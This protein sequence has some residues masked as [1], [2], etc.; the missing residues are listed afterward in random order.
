MN[1]PMDVENVPSQSQAQVQAPTPAPAFTPPA[2][3]AVPQVPAI[4]PDVQHAVNMAIAQLVA[5]PQ[6]LGQLNYIAQARPVRA[7]RQNLRPKPQ[8]FKR[9][10]SRLFAPP[11]PRIPHQPAMLDMQADEGS[12]EVEVRTNETQAF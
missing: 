6:A 8:T 7:P 4:A 12:S 10:G 1:D 9:P 11:P 3:K 5:N 2:Q